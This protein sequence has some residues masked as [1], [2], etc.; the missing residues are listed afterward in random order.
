MEEHRATTTTEQLVTKTNP[1]KKTKKPIRNGSKKVSTKSSKSSV[2]I[3][4]ECDPFEA[5][6]W[7]PL[8]PILVKKKFTW[9]GG[10][11]VFVCD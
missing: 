8:A 11:G 1:Q 6:M 3:P 4:L 5:Q 7:G 9:W 2:N 10:I